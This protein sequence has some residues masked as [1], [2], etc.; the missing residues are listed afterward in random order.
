MGWIA[1][2]ER[3]RAGSRAWQAGQHGPSWTDGGWG[4]WGGW[5][6]RGR[7]GRWVGERTNCL[8]ESA[9]PAANERAAHRVVRRRW[10]VDG[11]E[12][13]ATT[14]N[15]RLMEPR[16]ML[17]IRGIA[18]GLSGLQIVLGIYL[19]AFGPTRRGLIWGLGGA[20]VAWVGAE[21]LLNWCW[22]PGTCASAWAAGAAAAERSLLLPGPRS[23]LRSARGAPG[24][25]GAGRG[26][27]RLSPGAWAGVPSTLHG[28]STRGVWLR[29][30]HASAARTPRCPACGTTQAAA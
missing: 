11:R 24:A 19:A 20:L 30:E 22:R 16:T 21:E 25:A 13:Q 4:G 28:P 6:R 7:R 8:F 18:G 10:R 27:L 12:D 3:C 9:L 14:A 5:G 2:R 29:R 26:V 23:R 1:A 15:R 17:A